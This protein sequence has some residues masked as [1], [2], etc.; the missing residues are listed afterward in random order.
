MKRLKRPLLLVM[1]SMAI[2]IAAPMFTPFATWGQSEAN[3]ERLNLGRARNQARQAIELLN[4]RL[5][6]YRAE[7]AMHGPAC[8]APFTENDDG[9]LTF[10]FFGGP[11]ESTLT[12]ESVVT[13]T[14]NGVVDVIY[15]GPIRSNSG[16]DRLM[17]NTPTNNPILG[18]CLNRVNTIGAKNTARQAAEVE[19]G[20]LSQYRAEPSMHGPA[21]EAPFIENEDGSLTFTFRG[22]RPESLEYIIES[23]VT[24]TASGDAVIEYNGPIR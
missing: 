3:I 20:G 18:A 21:N 4:G 14:A 7:A 17:P 22:R 23:V 2:A 16:T 5:Q 15:N 8:L 24:V 9:S 12:V 1:L 10:A 19:N 13:V 11:P 6:A